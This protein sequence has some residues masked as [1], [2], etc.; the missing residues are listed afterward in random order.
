MIN[1][2][3]IPGEY[4]DV[5][6][7]NKERHFGKMR[8]IRIEDLK[9]SNLKKPWETFYSII[10]APKDVQVMYRFRILK[11]EISCV[12]KGKLY[13]RG[14]LINKIIIEEK[15]HTPLINSWLEEVKKFEE[16]DNSAR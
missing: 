2:K 8:Y 5:F 16:K 3:L 11:E 10:K 14:K 12:R 7:E 15:E 4:Y 13:T 1:F 6:F 9:E